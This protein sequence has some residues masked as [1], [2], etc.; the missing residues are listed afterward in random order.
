MYFFIYVITP[1]EDQ[2][3]VEMTDVY[4]WSNMPKFRSRY[5]LGY[6]GTFDGGGRNLGA[7]PTN[8]GIDPT[9]AFQMW[10]VL[11]IQSHR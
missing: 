2:M 11:P 4:Q 5:H 3:R 6:V 8:N 1:N 10:A 9:E 7:N